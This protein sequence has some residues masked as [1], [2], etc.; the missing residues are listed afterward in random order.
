MERR[1]PRWPDKSVLFFKRS[2]EKKY[3]WEAANNLAVALFSQGKPKEA[4]AYLT[5]VETKNSDDIV[6]KNLKEMNGFS[7]ASPDPK[8]IPISSPHRSKEDEMSFSTRYLPRLWIFR[9]PFGL[10]RV[11]DLSLRA[12][13]ILSWKT[14]LPTVEKT[15]SSTDS[16][17]KIFIHGAGTRGRIFM[18]QLHCKGIQVAGFIDQNEDCIQALKSA[19]CETLILE[20]SDLTTP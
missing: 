18:N 9:Y 12:L 17:K 8:L 4:T 2:L 11:R 3:S 13:G 14:F 6:N 20:S 10:S 7:P 19:D 5:Q 15:R 1:R 16:W